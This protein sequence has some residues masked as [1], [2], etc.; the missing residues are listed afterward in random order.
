MYNDTQIQ[1]GKLPSIWGDNTKT[2]TLSLTEDCNL[3][4]KYCYMTGKNNKEKMDF[5]IA[6]KVIDY[7]LFNRK[8]FNS[9]SVILGFI[10]GEPFIEIDLLDKISDYIKKQMFLLDH[11]WFNKYRFSISTN[12]I[13]Y[14]TPKVQKYINKNI[15]HLSVGFSIDGNR[16]KH[17]IQRI[18]PNG[19]GSYDD[20]IR[21]LPL[22][23]KQFPSATT[24][25]TF[26]H[27]DLP[28][29]KDSIISLWNLG[30]KNV[31][32]NIV[33]ED[34]WQNGDDIIFEAQLKQLADYILENKINCGRNIQ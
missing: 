20:V 14:D 21:N 28:Y 15:T 24:K 30:I 17:N 11:P 23:K 4:C 9:D 7:I 25:A 33:Y 1:M 3:A 34:V 6:K 10:G 29:L 16:E 13:L 26:S 31:L 18:Y 19:K 27:N 22:W 32:A 8:E 2:I 12:G 5:N